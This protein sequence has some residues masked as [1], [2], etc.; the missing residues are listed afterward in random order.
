MLADATHDLGREQGLRPDLDMRRRHG[1]PGVPFMKLA[2]TTRCISL[3]GSS[4]VVAVVVAI[5]RTP[6]G[7]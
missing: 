2:A 5:A 4:S 1:F 7:E 6:R 3:F